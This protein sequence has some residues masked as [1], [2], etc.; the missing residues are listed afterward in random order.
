MITSQLR[1]HHYLL[2]HGA[3]LVA[4]R[5]RQGLF[6]PV[7]FQRTGNTQPWLGNISG[8]LTQVTTRF[9]SFS[10]SQSYHRLL[11]QMKIPNKIPNRMSGTEAKAGFKCLKC[12]STACNCRFQ[13]DANWVKSHMF[14][15]QMNHRHYLWIE[16]NA[17]SGEKP[18]KQRSRDREG[19][20]WAGEL[21]Q[22]AFGEG[23]WSLF[24]NS[25][26]LQTL[27]FVKEHW[28]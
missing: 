17:F 22:Q 8:S 16:T 12:C 3:P 26:L 23:S 24:F 13:G 28:H 9:S 25:V 21:P 2:N 20:K 7:L 10:L 27:S 15:P 14:R 19:K 6:R 1:G 5:M 4:S 18:H 11:N